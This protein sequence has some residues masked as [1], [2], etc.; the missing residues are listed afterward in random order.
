MLKSKLSQM[1]ARYNADVAPLNQTKLA[2]ATGLSGSTINRMCKGRT[3]M[4]KSSVMEALGKFFDCRISDLIEF[5]KF[6]EGESVHSDAVQDP[7]SSED[8]EEQLREL[9]D[10]L[11]R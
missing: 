7:L 2:E 8:I 6:S 4:F 11:T 10:Y 3:S 9:P 5:E 1:I